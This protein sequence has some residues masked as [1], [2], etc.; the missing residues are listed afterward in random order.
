MRPGISQGIAV[1]R[2]LLEAERQGTAF[3]QHRQQL[4][5]TVA[6]QVHPGGP[7]HGCQI[8]HRPSGVTVTPIGTGD[9]VIEPLPRQDL[10]D[11]RFRRLRHRSSLYFPAIGADG[12]RHGHGC[13]E[14]QIQAGH[15]QRLRSRHDVLHGGVIRLRGAIDV[16]RNKDLR[17]YFAVFHPDP[18][19][20]TV[21]HVSVIDQKRS[22]LR[23]AVQAG[24]PK[25]RA[26]QESRISVLKG[27]YLKV[28]IRLA[29]AELNEQLRRAA[30]VPVVKPVTHAGQAARLGFAPIP[31]AFQ[32][33]RF[34]PAE[35]S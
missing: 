20:F 26:H 8:Q 18:A 27:V 17:P 34:L 32:N 12:Q 31:N 16:F 21:A 25:A 1:N 24:V 14:V 11:G 9:A 6:V 4:L 22:R 30:A 7:L 15:T 19:Q 29:G 35:L 33:S 28:V 5:L 10:P 3:S 2:A 23:A 13:R